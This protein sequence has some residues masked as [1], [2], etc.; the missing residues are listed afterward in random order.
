VSDIIDDPID[1][2]L[3]VRFDDTLTELA[4]LHY[5]SGDFGDSCIVVLVT[6]RLRRSYGRYADLIISIIT[7]HSLLAFVHLEVLILGTY[8]WVLLTCFCCFHVTNLFD[9]LN[10]AVW[11]FVRLELT[12][13]SLVRLELDALHL[14]RLN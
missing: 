8:I 11:Q 10:H 14:T 9:V 7:Y 5:Y 1:V 12:A 3:D 6:L 2:T 13:S 4:S